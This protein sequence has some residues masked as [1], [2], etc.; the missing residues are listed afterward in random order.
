MNH[1]DQLKTKNSFSTDYKLWL[2]LSLLVAILYGIESIYYALNHPEII[3]DD[4][5]HHIIWMRRFIDPELFPNDLIAD[6]F[7]SVAPWGFTTLYWILA[8]VGIDPVFAGKIIPAILA[9]VITYYGFKLSL[10]F[11][12]L[13][14]H[15]FITTLLLNQALWMEDDI[16]S[17]TPRAFIYPLFI[18]FLYYLIEKNI[19][20]VL[21]IIALQGL[22]YPQFVLIYLCLLTIRLVDQTSD[23]FRWQALLFGIIVSGIILIPYRISS[24]EFGPIITV[25]E[26]KLLP[27]FNLIDREWGRNIFFPNN[28]LIYW[29]LSPRSGLL[30]LGLLPPLALTGIALPFFLKRKEQFPLIHQVSEHIIILK[31]ILLTSVGLFCLSHL[32]LFQLHFPNRYIYHSVRVTLVLAAGVTLTLVLDQQYRYWKQKIQMGMSPKQ[33][34]KFGV[35]FSLGLILI[36]LPFFPPIATSQRLY[37]TGNAPEI[38]QFLLTQPKDSL[39]AS[40][41]EEADY[42]PTFAQRSTLVS[43][44]YSM[45]YHSGYYTPLRQRTIDLIQ[46]QYSTNWQTI[47]QFIQKYSIDFWLLD[48]QAFTEDYIQDQK[49]IRDVDQ[50]KAV[51]TQLQ[52]GQIPVLSIAIESCSIIQTDRHILLKAS[53]IEKIAENSL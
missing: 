16:I 22:F 28:P 20:A 33:W 36:I 47:R 13:P 42:I 8:K 38:Y 11:L 21:L 35:V 34:I 30:F 4:A 2:S 1:F 45:P 46:A 32:F 19:F 49:L 40:I 51:Q 23:K 15:G 48:R 25:A 44:E 39:V 24:N 26:A 12:P 14:I 6:Y 29:L 10:K 43:L 37:R 5:R 27:T 41:S 3:Q 7:R 53:C 52:Q 31:Q 17:A 9:I 18:A 50:E